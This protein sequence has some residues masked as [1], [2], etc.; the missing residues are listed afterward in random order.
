MCPPKGARHLPSMTPMEG[1]S[2]LKG[3]ALLLVLSLVRFGADQ[4]K[5]HGPV[6]GEGRTDLEWLLDESKQARDE[7]VR[8][9][10]PLAPGETLDPNRSPEEDLDRLP[11]VG[12]AMAMAIVGERERGGGF[13]RPEDLLR[14]RGIGPATLEKLRPFLDF[15]GGIPSELGMTGIGAYGGGYAGA[16][17]A[18]SASPMAAP[19]VDVVQGAGGGPAPGARGSSGH[20]MNLNS[21]SSEEFQALPGIGP[22]L[23]E[24][25]LESRAR[26]GPFRTPDDLLRVRGIGPATL[27]RIRDL[28]FAGIG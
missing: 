5:H 7:R 19:P 24:R 12:P 23:A 3:G 2:L 21:A 4:W 6:V 22:A 27:A 1:K 14:V 28:V 25:I 16:A 17:P 13:D 8:R 26:E 10:R 9:T 20:R 11:G 15:S 18:P